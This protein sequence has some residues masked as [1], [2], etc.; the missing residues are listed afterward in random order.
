MT[1][2]YSNLADFDVRAQHLKFGVADR[3]KV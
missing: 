1:R 3:L 2:H